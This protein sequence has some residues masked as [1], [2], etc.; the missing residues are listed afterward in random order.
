M[1]NRQYIARS[2]EF[3]FGLLFAVP[4]FFAFEGGVRLAPPLAELRQAEERALAVG[5]VAALIGFVIGLL[6]V[7]RSRLDRFDSRLFAL[8]FF[9]VLVWLIMSLAAGGVSRSSVII[10]LQTIYATAGYFVVGYICRRKRPLMVRSIGWSG[11]CVFWF[12]V[13]ITVFAALVL[14]IG[15]TVID[16]GM[17]AYR[18]GLIT[19]HIGIFYNP[20]MNRFFPLYLSA[21]GI[22][23]LSL[24]L[25]QGRGGKRKVLYLIGGSACLVSVAFMHSRTAMLAAFLS[26]VLLCA[27]LFIR[28]KPVDLLRI[29]GAGIALLIGGLVMANSGGSTVSFSRVV[30]DTLLPMLGD[31]EFHESD[32]GRFRAFRNGLAMLASNPLGSGFQPASFTPH[33]A[34]VVNTESG[35]FDLVARA[36]LLALVLNLSLMLPASWLAFK[37]WR[38][39]IRMLKANVPLSPEFPFIYAV[40]C[41]TIVNVLFVNVFINASTEPY[42]GVCFWALLAS[43]LWWNGRHSFVAGKNG[44]ADAVKRASRRIPA[45]M[46]RRRETA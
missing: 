36:G 17:S 41:L 45:Q 6:A 18:H 34:D 12:G 28:L 16:G 30:E 1:L 27:P 32:L 29:V 23:L 3:A 26:V 4:I 10:L 8:L 19:N 20:K 15:Q 22:V 40:S 11:L 9:Y 39:S 43:S 44:R 46:R 14:Y 7:I 25:Y 31:S 5:F 42:Y 21:A 38:E 33:G 37:R 35:Y 24:G 2:R 13:A